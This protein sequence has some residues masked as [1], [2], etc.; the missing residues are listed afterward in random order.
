MNTKNL[1]RIAFLLVLALLATL[2][3]RAQTAS[4][5]T[6]LRPPAG[7]KVALVEFA[8]LECPDCARAAPLLEEAAKTYKIPVVVYDFP[9]PQHP[10][11]FD[12]SVYAHYYRSKSTPKNDLETKFRLFIYENQPAITQQNLRQYV[13]KF[14]KANNAPAPFIVDPQG[15]LAAAVRAAKDKGIAADVQHTP[16]IY[17]V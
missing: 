10:W 1:L 5:A 11:A 2:A 13:D 4:Q 7:A 6:I 8:D 9:L 12:A 15:K 3:L 14:G 16:T 17:V